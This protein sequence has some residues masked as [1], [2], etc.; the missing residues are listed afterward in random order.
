VHVARKP[1]YY[2]GMTVRQPPNHRRTLAA[3]QI[4]LAPMEGVINASM[5]EFLTAMGGYD[6]CVTEFVRV[7]NVLLPEKVFFR[8]CPELKQGGVTAS[9]FWLPGE[10]RE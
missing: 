2:A 3:Q 9:G 7:T 6:R 4:V 10:N 5:R 1:L 8:L